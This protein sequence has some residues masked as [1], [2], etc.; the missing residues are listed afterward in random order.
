MSGVAYA[1]VRFDA[2]SVYLAEDIDVLQRLLAL[3]LVADTDPALL[4]SK[5]ADELRRALLD[6][7]WGD[8]VVTWMELSGVAVDVYTF[9]PVY[10]S[11][12]LPSELIG[13]QLQF[14][15]LFRDA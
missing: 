10:G 13:A 9:L 1:V 7:R 5:G 8:A 14:K 6:E 3:E 15:R 4:T 12:E 11:E 2:P